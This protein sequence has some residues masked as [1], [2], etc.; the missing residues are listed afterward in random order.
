[1]WKR[2]DSERGPRSPVQAA[3]GLAQKS[4]PL[5]RVMNCSLTCPSLGPAGAIRT[6]AVRIAI[7]RPRA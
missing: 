4:I 7:F 6:C 5:P 2:A 3:A 1:M